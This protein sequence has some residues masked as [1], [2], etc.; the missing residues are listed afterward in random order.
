[1]VDIAMA[2]VRKRV[3]PSFLFSYVTDRLSS[4]TSA[5]GK[6]TNSTPTAVPDAPRGHCHDNPA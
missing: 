4:R 3:P 5:F 6:S 2:N 1:L